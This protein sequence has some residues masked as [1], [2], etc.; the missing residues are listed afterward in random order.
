MDYYGNYK[1]Y[2]E[3]HEKA[4]REKRAAENVKKYH[5]DVI[6]EYNNQIIAIGRANWDYKL[7]IFG[8]NSAALYY[9]A[10]PGSGCGS[11]IF[12]GTNILKYH[13]QDLKRYEKNT[14]ESIIP[15]D[16]TITEPGFFQAL[17]IA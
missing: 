13:L 7:V 2:I 11:G 12:C 3:K 17:N 10:K 9:I 4:Q 14:R 8:D 6:K 15:S 5:I 16:W 1:N